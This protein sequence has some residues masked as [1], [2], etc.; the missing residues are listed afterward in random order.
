MKKKL[1]ILTVLLCAALLCSCTVIPASRLEAMFRTDRETNISSGSGS[2]P[3]ST[4]APGTE[5]AESVSDT[6]TISREEYDKYRQFSEMFEIYDF[7]KNYFYQEPDTDKMTEYAIRGLMSGLD[8]P[9]SFYYNPKEYEE[10]WEDDEGNYVGIGVLIQSNMDTQKC[11]IVR[12][13][14]GGPA[15]A[16]GVQRG[17]ILY[18]VGD[19]LFVNANNLQEA[20]D[21][22]RGVPDT[23]VDVTFIR[24]DEEITY[25][26][27][28]KEVN[29]NQVESRMIDD[30]VGY[31]ALYQFAGQCEKE[32]ENDLN[33]LI[34]QGAKGVIIDLRDNTG[35]WVDQ[36]RYIA[37]LFM[38]KGELCYLKYRD[39]EDHTEYLTKDGKVDVKLVILINENTASSSEILTGALRDCAGAVTVGVKSFGKGI[40]QG[41]YQVG[42][43][44]AGYQMTI[45]QYYTPNGSAVHK[46]GI[47]PD[48]EVSLPEGDNGMYEFA[49]LKRDV[50]LIK[51]QAVMNEVL[52]SD[53]AVDVSEIAK[54]LEQSAAATEQP[55]E[56][57]AEQPTELPTEALNE[58]AGDAEQKN[59]EKKQEENTPEK[60]S[61]AGS[62]EK[63]DKFLTPANI[64]IIAAAAAALI[65]IVGAL[66]KAIR[67]K[68]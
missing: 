25:T 39:D 31:I 63:T 49:D 17:D 37:D 35:G 40:I 15:E 53:G 68:E 65:I 22:M 44:G 21:I 48:F 6:V 52:Q 62:S 10:L 33:K 19:D 50:Q 54:K 20:V 16:A 41:V 9:Y 45:A 38:D 4:A 8:D 24:G 26:I 67:K 12:V 42:N 47:T 43:K 18:K 61:E 59:G 3:Q 29:V 23:D 14:K 27:T 60:S 64:A 2:E 46:I 56:Q 7:A 5:P 34:S 36:A 57:P 66:K 13:F 55:T 30:S 1:L 51:A 58:A 28:R 32:F 11:T